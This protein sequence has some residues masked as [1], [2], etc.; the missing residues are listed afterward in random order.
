[1]LAKGLIAEILKLKSTNTILPA[2]PRTQG[3]NE[4]KS[5]IKLQSVFVL[6]LVISLSPLAK[7]SQILNCTIGQQQGTAKIEV[8][9][10][11]DHPLLKVFKIELV[12]KLA[13][14]TAQTGSVTGTV[15]LAGLLTAQ[16]D[17]KGSVFASGLM[18]NSSS[19]GS[20]IIN[21]ENITLQGQ[22]KSDGQLF[23]RLYDS[24]RV[25]QLGFGV[26]VICR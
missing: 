7:A 16:T 24:D 9:S 18:M 15:N 22:T 6:L 23:L 11:I 12:S 26:N 21:P 10:V 5:L 14:P 17:S 4:M 1:M 19:T 20:M 8:L 3:E 13:R 25:L 2:C